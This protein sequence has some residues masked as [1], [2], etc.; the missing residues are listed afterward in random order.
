MRR[1]TKEVI[2]ILRARLRGSRA[3]LSMKLMIVGLEGQGKTT[4]VH[5]LNKDL[6][7]NSDKS[8]DGKKLRELK[9]GCGSCIS[10]W[11]RL[12]YNWC[13]PHGPP[14]VPSKYSGGPLVLPRGSLV[15][16]PQS[17]GGPSWSSG[18]PSWSS[19]VLHG[20]LVVPRGP[21]LVPFWS[22]CGMALWWMLL[23]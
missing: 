9:C 18:G 1:N 10:V 6:K 5:R 15:V 22:S 14:G 3:C 8:T 2:Y 23:C 12:T 19:G 7:Y 11:I 17:S 13:C 20:P 16:P 21:L 4:L